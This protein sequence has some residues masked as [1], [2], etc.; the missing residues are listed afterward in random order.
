MRYAIYFTPPEGSLLTLAAA[1]WLGRDVHA[2]ERCFEPHAWSQ[3]VASPRRYGFH[4]TLKA[5][6]RLRDGL[7]EAALIDA[8]GSFCARNAPVTAPNVRIARLGP[9]FALVPGSASPRLNA[10][11]DLIVTHFE[12]LRAPLSEA[13]IARRKPETLT[14]AQR[15]LL[16][17][18]GYP[19]VF[20]EF[21]LH[22]TLT[23]PVEDAD[24]AAVEAALQ[25]RFAQS[26]GQD[27]QIGHL[28]VFVERHAG[29]AFELL[30]QAPL[31]AS[32]ASAGQ[33]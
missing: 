6:F 4:A 26:L 19:Y 2:P 1:Q 23:G 3:L 21:R 11:A 17:R 27:L 8:L 14:P 22:M 29:A 30:I 7:D 31:T 18:W 10:F 16:E 24:S 20:D 28:C 13:E 5:P 25:R 32:D 12:P 33:I 15:A 9:F